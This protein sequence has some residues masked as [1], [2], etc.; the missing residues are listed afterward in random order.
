M[1]IRRKHGRQDSS[2]ARQGVTQAVKGFD[3]ANIDLNWKTPDTAEV[4]VEVGRSSINGSLVVDDD[5]VQLDLKLPLF[6]KAMQGQIS[7]GIND[8]FTKVFGDNE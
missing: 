5:Y 3:A 2:E 4:V 8:Q 7:K 1:R 6:L